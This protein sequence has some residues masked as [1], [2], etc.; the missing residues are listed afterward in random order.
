MGKTVEETFLSYLMKEA[1]KEDVHV[2]VGKYMKTERNEAIERLFTESNFEKVSTE[3][4]LIIWEYDAKEKG[5]PTF[6]K[7]FKVLSKEK[8]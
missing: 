6:P 4:G 3:G 2:L 1:L 8:K 5:I 7:W